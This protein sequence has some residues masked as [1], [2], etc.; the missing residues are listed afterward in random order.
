MRSTRRV[1]EMNA[2]LEPYN[3]NAYMILADNYNRKRCK[4]IVLG[5]DGLAL[6]KNP[7]VTSRMYTVKYYY[8]EGFPVKKFIRIANEIRREQGQEPLDV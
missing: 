7:Y 3:L 2:L 4:V 6:R 8:P 5:A 1:D